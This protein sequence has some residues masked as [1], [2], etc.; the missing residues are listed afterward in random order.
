[1]GFKKDIENRK[2]FNEVRNKLKD[3]VSTVTKTFENAVDS[4]ST[5]METL[6]S[7]QFKKD[8]YS[9]SI[10]YVEAL[11]IEANVDVETEVKISIDELEGFTSVAEI[12][13]ALAVDDASKELAEKENYIKTVFNVLINHFSDEEELEVEA[14]DKTIILKIKDEPVKAEAEAEA[15][16]D[17]EP[18]E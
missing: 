18:V 14:T 8:I 16:A 3:V 15:E 2:K 11:V 5:N 6:A 1:M 4:I 10:S 7:K 9:K 13:T 12:I 17:K